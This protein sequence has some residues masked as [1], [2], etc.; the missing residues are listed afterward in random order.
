MPGGFGGGGGGPG[1]C[2]PPGAGG[3]GGGGGGAPPGCTGG[4]RG[5]ASCI[6]GSSSLF[7]R[8]L[9]SCPLIQSPVSSGTITTMKFHFLITR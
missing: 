3:G 8:S 7:V 4:G 9:K 2:E 5:G 1:G 6:T